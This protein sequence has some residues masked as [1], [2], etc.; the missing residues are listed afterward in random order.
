MTGRR[1]CAVTILT[2][3]AFPAGA[4]GLAGTWKGTNDMPKFGPV[5]TVFEFRVD[6]NKLSGTFSNNLI[7]T[8]PIHDGIVKGTEVSFKVKLQLRVFGY[9][10]RF[11]GNELALT[12]RVVEG[13]PLDGMPAEIKVTVKRAK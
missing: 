9:A 4:Q 1:L 3:L 8:T 5:T 6:G 2:L 10:G 13:P 7:P 12:S 11:K